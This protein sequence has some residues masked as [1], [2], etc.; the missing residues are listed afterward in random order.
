MPKPA[1]INQNTGCVVAVSHAGRP[2]GLATLRE[3]T[4]LTSA[5]RRMRSRG[6]R[7]LPVVDGDGVLVGIFDW[8]GALQIIA[9]EL[10]Q[11]A[12]VAGTQV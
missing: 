3:N 10:H 5:M 11:A 4:P 2:L 9:T 7:R 1:A 12:R 6:V 8:H